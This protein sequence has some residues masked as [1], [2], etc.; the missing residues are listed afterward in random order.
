M[1]D[2]NRG[3]FFVELDCDED[4]DVVVRAGYETRDASCYDVDPDH[5]VDAET[6]FDYL[7]SD[8]SWMA[9]YELERRLERMADDEGYGVLD[10]CELQEGEDGEWRLVQTRWDEVYPDEDEDEESEEE[11]AE[12]E[13]EEGPTAV[14]LLVEKLDK[15]GFELGKRQEA[16]SERVLDMPDEETDDA[17]TDAADANGEPEPPKEPILRPCFDQ[18]FLDRLVAEAIEDIRGEIEFEDS[19]Y[20]SLHSDYLANSGSIDVGGLLDTVTFDGTYFTQ[21][22]LNLTIPKEEVVGFFRDGR[23]AAA[24]SSAGYCSDEFECAQGLFRRVLK[25]DDE[26]LRRAIREQ[27]KTVDREEFLSEYPEFGHL[28]PQA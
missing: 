23:M 6:L 15:M 21:E 28:L 3:D 7:F 24:L 18:E 8:C 27:L 22:T 13:E 19:L 5:A 20:E 9:Q 25:M 26:G 1:D 10:Y 16:S 17:N 11:D 14:N 12:E 2:W 4:G